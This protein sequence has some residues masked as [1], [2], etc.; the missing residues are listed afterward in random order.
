MKKL[1]FQL[2]TDP[3][4]N[5][6]DVV[7]AYDAGVDHVTPLGGITPAEVGRLVEGVVF[8]RPPAAKK[9]SALFVTGSNMAA[10]EA[11]LAAVRGQ[12]FGQFRVSVMLDSNGSNTTAAA[13]IAQL[14][15][16]VPLAGKRAV[17]LG[18]TGPVGQ[19][20]A[21]MLALAGASVVLTS[22]S[23]ARASAACRAMNERFGIALQPA[24]ASD[25]TTTAASLAEAHIVMTTGAAGLE[26]LPQALW[27]NHPT[28][29]VVIDTNTTPPAGIGGIELQD[30]GTLRHGKRC[31]GGL[32]FGGLKLELQRVCVAQLFDANDRVLD[33]PEVFALASE[34]VRRR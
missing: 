10:G 34:L 5:T 25:P 29:A 30:Q 33:A 12:F 20:A 13:A 16:E 18:G 31:Y 23:L 1:L 21:T 7:V 17:I 6:F 4:P 26:L 3:I 28:L 22:R 27:A 19:R 9:F 2:D 32:G 14:A 8:T 15:A 11:V 24:V